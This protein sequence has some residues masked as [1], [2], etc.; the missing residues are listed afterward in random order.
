MGRIQLRLLCLAAL[1]PILAGGAKPAP[2]I[3][4][5]FAELRKS[6]QELYA[7]LYQMPK[8]ADLHVHLS[9][10][11]YAETYLRIAA[12][13]GLCIEPRTHAIVA[14]VSPAGSPRCG[15]NRENAAR[16]AIEQYARERDDRQ[17]LDAQLCAWS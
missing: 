4:Q 6:P 16:R 3:E 5:R 10:A 17:S 12:E 2:S 14:P 9:G 8:G 7:F 15:L 11:V 13:D 1:W